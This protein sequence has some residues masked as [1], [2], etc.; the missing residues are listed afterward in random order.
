MVR[1]LHA[2]LWI[3]LPACSNVGELHLEVVNK[4]LERGLIE[5]RLG[6]AYGLEYPLDGLEQKRLAGH[7]GTT[8]HRIGSS[9]SA[10]SPSLLHTKSVRCCG[11]AIRTCAPQL[12]SLGF[13]PRPDWWCS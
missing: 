6:Q 13:V 10:R 11:A 3:V 1:A 2:I 9:N 4:H 12:Q 5:G 7:V 8:R